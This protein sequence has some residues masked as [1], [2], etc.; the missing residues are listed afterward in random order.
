[1]SRSEEM[2]LNYSVQVGFCT[3]VFSRSPQN[4]QL[5]ELRT[6]RYGED[7]QL[8]RVEAFLSS[9]HPGQQS[10]IRLWHKEHSQEANARFRCLSAVSQEQRSGQTL[11][12]YK[13][14][15]P[16][17]WL[18]IEANTAASWSVR[19]CSAGHLAADSHG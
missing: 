12:L 6:T 5:K 15:Q 18:S 11:H 3:L 8:W 10:I 7:V 17:V 14:S 16:T 1:M 2:K 19:G 13:A 9:P 4:G